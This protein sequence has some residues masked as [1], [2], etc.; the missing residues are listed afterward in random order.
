MIAPDLSMPLL[1]SLIGCDFGTKVT[2]PGVDD[3]PCQHQAEHVVQ[4]YDNGQP[5]APMKFC[6]GH[7]AFMETQTTPREVSR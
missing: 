6:A 1:R 3:A 5:L 2:V 4:L 7:L